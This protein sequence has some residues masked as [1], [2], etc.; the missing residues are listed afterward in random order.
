MMDFPSSPEVSKRL[1]DIITLSKR[2]VRSQLITSVHVYPGPSLNWQSCNDDDGDDAVQ[3][4]V[5]H[6]VVHCRRKRPSS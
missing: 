1:G 4:K 6:A 3:D 2:L 5:P